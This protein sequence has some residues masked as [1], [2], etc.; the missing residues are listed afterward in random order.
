VVGAG[1]IICLGR[2][3]DLHMAQLMPLPLT[4]CKILT[5]FTFPVP[6]H[7]GSPGQR[8][9]KR[10][11]LCVCP[12]VI[13]NSSARCIHSAYFRAD[14]YESP[15]GRHWPNRVVVV[16]GAGLPRWLLLLL[17]VVVLVMVLAPRSYISDIIAEG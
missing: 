9:V 2:D 4:V 3:A 14:A 16:S 8:A 1:M 12:V 6:T 7:P 15:I 11:C 10:S 13:E 17:V 5:G